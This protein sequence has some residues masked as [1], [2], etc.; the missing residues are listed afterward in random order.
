MLILNY[1]KGRVSSEYLAPSE[2]LKKIDKSNETSSSLQLTN[3]EVE[4]VK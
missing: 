2:C 1:F 4:S 3:T